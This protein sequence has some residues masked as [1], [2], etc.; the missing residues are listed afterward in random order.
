MKV[1]F[2]LLPTYKGR[3]KK[4]MQA[5]KV[6]ANKFILFQ[7]ITE[8]FCSHWRI[9]EYGLWSFQAGGTKLERFLRKNQLKGNH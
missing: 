9:V 1:K 2:F 3:F 6:A 5:Q 4:E 7:P 8:L